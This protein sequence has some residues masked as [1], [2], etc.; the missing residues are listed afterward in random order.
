MLVLSTPESV[1]SLLLDSRLAGTNQLPRDLDYVD[2]SRRC[3]QPVQDARLRRVVDGWIDQFDRHHG[4]A[5]CLLVENDRDPARVDHEH[6]AVSVLMR[7]PDLYGFINDRLD[8]FSRAALENL[9]MH[10]NG[11]RECLLRTFRTL[12]LDL[13]VGDVIPDMNPLQSRRVR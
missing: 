5:V 3:L 2:P 1:T 7:M 4:S 11:Q 13:A 8:V 12:W 6:R 10:F 9:V